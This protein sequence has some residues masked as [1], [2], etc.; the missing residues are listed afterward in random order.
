MEGNKHMSSNYTAT[1]TV[2][3]SPIE[4][5]EA[6]R[7]VRAWWNA[8]IAGDPAKVGDLFIQEAPGLHRAELRVTAADPGTRMVWHVE[9]SDM[10]FLQDTTEWVGTDIVFDIEPEGTGSKLR[11]THHGLMPGQECY[12][13]CENAWGGYMASLHG[14]ITTGVGRPGEDSVADD[15]AERDRAATPSSQPA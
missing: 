3:Q 5:Y 14:L 11:F 6:V 10:T 8:R 15:V 2:S 7:N 1:F 12:D 13:I 9:A 4:V